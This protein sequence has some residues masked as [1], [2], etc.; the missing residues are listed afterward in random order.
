M[1][2]R[3]TLSNALPAAIVQD[4]RHTVNISDSIEMPSASAMKQIVRR[5]RKKELPSEPECSAALVIPHSLKTTRNGE[6]N[7]LLFDTKNG[8]MASE[9]EML[10]ED[11]RIIGFGTD[12]A[13]RKLANSHVWFLDGTFKT[14]P[15]LF[16]QIYTIHYMFHGHTFPAVYALLPGKTQEIYASMLELL[17]SVAE[18]KGIELNPKFIIVD[19]ELASINALQHT[20]PNAKVTGCFFHLCQNIQR[21]I[22]KNGLVNIYKNN[23]DVALSIRKL[24][25]LAFLPPAEICNAFSYLLSCAPCEAE[26]VYKYFGDTFVLGRSIAARRRGR[27]GRLTQRHPPRFPPSVWSIHHLQEYNLPRTNNNLEAWHRRF[28]TV[29]ERYHMGVFLMI[30]EFLKEEHRTQQEVERIIAGSNQQKKKKEKRT[31]PKGTATCY[32]YC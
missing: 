21:S 28:E 6:K 25:A 10:L 24:S 27:P 3:S 19:F 18:T 31:N 17:I 7:F 14:C 2:S 22:Q 1:K 12:D 13:L 23:E 29:V 32:C 5:I 9:N 8:E 20:F 4:I 16:H 26:V 15:K 30:K 11:M